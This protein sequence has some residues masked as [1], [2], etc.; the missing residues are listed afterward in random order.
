MRVAWRQVTAKSTAVGG[1]RRLIGQR[2]TSAG[3]LRVL[4]MSLDL[5]DEPV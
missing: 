2:G 3:M 4:R 5:Y 1:G